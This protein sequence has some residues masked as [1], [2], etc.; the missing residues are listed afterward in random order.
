VCVCVGV[1]VCV[2]GCVCVCV[3]AEYMCCEWIVSVLS[4]VSVLGGVSCGVACECIVTFW[5]LC[6]I[7]RSLLIVATPYFYIYKYTYAKQ[8]MCVTV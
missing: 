6:Y 3:C 5:H 8:S 2:C 1:C 4:G 7:L